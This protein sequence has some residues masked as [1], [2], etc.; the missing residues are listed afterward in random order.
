MVFRLIGF[1]ESFAEQFVFKKSIS[2]L[3]IECQISLD[4]KLNHL[5]VLHKFEFVVGEVRVCRSF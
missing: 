4:F 2:R 1:Q 3:E 5:L